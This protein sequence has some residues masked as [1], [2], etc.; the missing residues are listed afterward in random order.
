MKASEETQYAPQANRPKY[1][2]EIDLEEK[3]RR[4]RE[5]VKRLRRE[6]YETAKVVLNLSQHKHADSE[7]VIPLNNPGGGLDDRRRV[8]EGDDVYF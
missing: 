7:I 2:S 8:T 6:L 1:W 4:L 3:C 5:E